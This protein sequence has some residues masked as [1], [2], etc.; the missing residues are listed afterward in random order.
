[1]PV[2]FEQIEAFLASLGSVPH[3]KSTGAR[4]AARAKLHAVCH[5]TPWPVDGI[6]NST[7]AKL[8][9]L[10]V[11]LQDISARG[12]RILSPRALNAGDQF[13]LHLPHDELGTYHLLYVVKHCKKARPQFFSL[14][15]ELLSSLTEAASPP[16][17]DAKQIQI[18]QSI[19]S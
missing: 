11:R 14:G 3:D 6:W 4:H 15:A 8:T 10:E 7:R 2:S 19:L 18:Q 5:I 1:M 16:P 17:D 9:R 13:V 12:I